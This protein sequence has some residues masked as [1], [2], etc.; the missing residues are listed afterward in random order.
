M[1]CLFQVLKVFISYSSLK[2]LFIF[3]ISSNS[4][5]DNQNNNA[6]AEN[7][8]VFESDVQYEILNSTNSDSEYDIR[9]LNENASFPVN[10]SE[11]EIKDD[12]HVSLQ[13]E[14]DI[15]IIRS[16]TTRD[17]DICSCDLL[18]N[19]CDINCCCDHDCNEEDIKVFS[20][21][22]S[23]ILIPDK[24]YCYQKDIIF[25]NNTIYKM[26]KD[27]ESSLFCIVHD[28]FKEHLRFKDL[29]IIRSHR[30]LNVVLKHLSKNT[31][32]WDTEDD[33]NIN[34]RSGMIAGNP[35]FIDSEL[36]NH[37]KSTKH[38]SKCLLK[39]F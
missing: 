9:I 10:T 18:L 30:D 37:E 24:N 32:S 26:E 27:P 23:Q 4:A 17:E 36:K 19:A 33:D 16:F 39:I 22:H 1:N 6:Y 21:C 38:W 3:I 2:F 34:E 8:T 5:E 7:I 15:S 35:I 13:S 31:F 29:P 28:N 14:I 11:K 12:S 25:R 20:K